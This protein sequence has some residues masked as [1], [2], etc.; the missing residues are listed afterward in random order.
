MHLHFLS[1]EVLRQLEKSVLFRMCF[2][3]SALSDSFN[4]VPMTQSLPCNYSSWDPQSVSITFYQLCVFS[5]NYVLG[6]SGND[7]NVQ[8]YRVLY[9]I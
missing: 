8:M 3:N 2:I 6:S 1:T 9:A 7:P 4:R 5:M